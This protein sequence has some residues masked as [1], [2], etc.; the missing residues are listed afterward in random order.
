MTSQLE[1]AQTFKALHDSGETFIIPNPW[2]TGSAL[3]LEAVGFKALA[4]TSAGFARAIGRTDGQVSLEEKLDHCRAL[5]SATSVPISADFENGFADTPEGVAE[6][7]LKLA[8]TGLVGGS[9]EDWSGTQI[10]DFDLAVARI[11]AGAEAVAK[12][13][14]PFTLT[15]RAEG[16]FRGVGDLDEI[17]R[18]LQAYEAAGADVLYAPRLTDLE[19]VQAVLGAVSAP[20]NVLAVYLPD[21]SL[22]QY[23]ELGVGRLSVGNG[24]GNYAWQAALF[25]AEQMMDEGSFGWVP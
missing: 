2:D 18:R 23:A 4:T 21:V 10:Y 1:K 7:L 15:A 24:L 9:I 8:D 25:A 14:F 12:L 13:A 3:M 17:I 20:I 19:Q 22:A 16:L 5:A 6:N 11:A